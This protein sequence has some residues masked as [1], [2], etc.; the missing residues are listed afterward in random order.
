MTQLS[1][2]DI[3]R[4]LE[5]NYG[6]DPE[7][8]QRRAAAALR[9]LVIPGATSEAAPATAEQ[10]RRADLLEKAEQRA[11][12]NMARAIGCKVYNLSQ[13]RASKQSPG[14]PDLWITKRAI[15]LAFWWE[16]KRQ[17]GGQR[18]TAQMEFGEECTAGLVN[19]GFG[20]RYHFAEFLQAHGIMPPTIPRD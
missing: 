6:V 3:A 1:Q 9:R 15:G 2:D 13:A 17:V 18:S 14:L 12:G 10:Q 20:D 11:I 16:T 8:A 5:Q 7:T 4:A 19:Y